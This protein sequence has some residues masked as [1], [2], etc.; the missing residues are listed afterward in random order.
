[1]LVLRGA[2][3]EPLRLRLFTYEGIEFTCH[4]QQGRCWYECQGKSL[5]SRKLKTGELERLEKCLQQQRFEQ[6]PMKLVQPT[7]DSA[8]E[9]T[10][11]RQGKAR[12][13][14]ATSSY[15]G[16]KQAEFRR[17]QTIVK[18]IRSL[19]PIPSREIERAYEH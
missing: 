9:L 11:W 3:A 5:A 2:W 7:C 17:F 14:R 19:A 10:V 18:S 15:S 13:V 4:I 16:P 8:D 12:T 6:L 1:M